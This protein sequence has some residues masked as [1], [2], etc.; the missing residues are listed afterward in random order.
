MALVLFD[1]AGTVAAVARLVADPDGLRAEFALLVRTDLK[2]RGI[3]SALLQKLVGYARQR[4]IAEIWG[5]V[6]LENSAMLVICREF[7]FK[8]SPATQGI[9]RA[10][11]TLA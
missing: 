4:G 8:L 11:L 5:D 6:L 2:G 10:S 3:G 9:V 1:S 7:G